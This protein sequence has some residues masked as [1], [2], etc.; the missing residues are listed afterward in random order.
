M[1]KIFPNDA[2]ARYYLL[3]KPNLNQLAGSLGWGL[4]HDPGKGLP[5][6][7]THSSREKNYRNSKMSPCK[8]I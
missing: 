5:H 8:K 4:V 7:R 2:N 3:R 6:P 1:L